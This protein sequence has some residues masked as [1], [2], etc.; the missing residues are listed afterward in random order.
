M[1]A[2]HIMCAYVT[3]ASIMQIS[4][5]T[6]IISDYNSYYNNI[7]FPVCAV[8]L[9]VSLYVMESSR[10]YYVIEIFRISTFENFMI[11]SLIQ[12]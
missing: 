5:K 4:H 8:T 3:P 6:I 11:L 9:A 2:V 1:T 12:C 10:C 7:I